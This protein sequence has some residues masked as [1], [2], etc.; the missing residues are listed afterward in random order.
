MRARTLTI[1]Y[2]LPILLTATLMVVRAKFSF[3]F[4]AGI[5]C[6]VVALATLVWLNVPLISLSDIAA[7]GESVIYSRAFIPASLSVVLVCAIPHFAGWL[8]FQPLVG[9]LS[10]FLW[11]RLCVW[12]F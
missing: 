2:L 8:F 4:Y 5:G 3:H 10:A 7:N 9:F 1:T 6:A 12:E 11:L